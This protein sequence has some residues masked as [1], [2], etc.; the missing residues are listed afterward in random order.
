MYP[1]ATTSFKEAGTWRFS[2]LNFRSACVNSLKTFARS[3]SGATAEGP[4]FVEAGAAAGGEALLP[5]PRHRKETKQVTNRTRGISEVC[6]SAS[7][8][9]VARV[10]ET[11][12]SWNSHCGFPMHPQHVT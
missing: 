5:H 8:I 11:A 2:T 1:A 6:L 10:D 4:A 9:Q 12:R 3:A 7:K